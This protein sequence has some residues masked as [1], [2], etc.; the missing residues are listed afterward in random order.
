ME[1]GVVQ[2]VRPKPTLPLGP[3]RKQKG[4]CLLSAPAIVR[5][6][7][8]GLQYCGESWGVNAPSLLDLGSFEGQGSVDRVLIR[9]F[10]A[11]FSTI[12]CQS[13]LF[14]GTP[15]PG[16]AILFLTLFSPQGVISWVCKS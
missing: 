3:M 1:R 9:R 4:F 14:V 16:L 15:V 5:G 2:F 11:R 8:P 6:I 10:C 7:L 13:T 12:E